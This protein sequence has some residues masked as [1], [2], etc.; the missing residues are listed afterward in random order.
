MKDE[1]IAR[2]EKNCAAQLHL[3]NIEAPNRTMFVCERIPNHGGV[4][5][6]HPNENVTVTWCYPDRE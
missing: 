4:H 2:F 1:L 6:A 5:R 3:P